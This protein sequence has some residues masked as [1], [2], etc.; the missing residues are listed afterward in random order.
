MSTCDQSHSAFKQQAWATWGALKRRTSATAFGFSSD[1]RN[2]V[3]IKQCGE[4]D[5]RKRAN[6]IQI[7]AAETVDSSHS[8]IIFRRYDFLHKVS[9]PSSSHFTK[10]RVGCGSV[11][12][13]LEPWL[14]GRGFESHP[15]LCRVWPWA[16]RSPSINIIIIINIFN[17]FNV[18][19]C[20]D[21]NIF[22]WLK[23]NYALRKERLHSTEWQL[24]NKKLEGSSFKFVTPVPK[25]EG[26]L[27]ICP[28]WNKTYQ[29]IYR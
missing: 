22:V 8:E 25:H 29:I 12:Q 19:Y 1:T 11:A 15:L 5:Q 7:L 6:S 2:A 24:K 16:G 17:V 10:L 9:S 21:Q 28:R 20:K 26:K 27:L 18:N 4:V 3:H 14:R 23:G 13:W